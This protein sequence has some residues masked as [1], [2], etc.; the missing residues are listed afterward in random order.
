MKVLTAFMFALAGALTLL[1]GLTLSTIWD[2]TADSPDSTYIETGALWLG[3]ALI[4]LLAG[5]VALR[6]ASRG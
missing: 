1:A 2:D 5:V 4:A 3:L 6:R